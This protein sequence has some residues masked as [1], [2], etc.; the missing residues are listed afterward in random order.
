[1][2]KLWN[3]LTSSKP[4]P[5]AATP[6]NLIRKP[7]VEEAIRKSETAVTE[8]QADLEEIRKRRQRLDK[9]RNENHFAPS[10]Y[11]AFKGSQ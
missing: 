8:G 9:I 2:I 3:W 10:I 6:A 1:M 4:P 11:K 7:E 5:A